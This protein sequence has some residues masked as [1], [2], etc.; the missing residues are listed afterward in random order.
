MNAPLKYIECIINIVSKCLKVVWIRVDASLN[1][2][3]NSRTSEWSYRQL[4]SNFLPF[5]KVC[6]SDRKSWRISLPYDL[7]L[8][9]HVSFWSNWYIES[10]LSIWLLWNFPSFFLNLLE[11][12]G[13]FSQICFLLPAAFREFATYLCITLLAWQAIRATFTNLCTYRYVLLLLC[14]YFVMRIP[15]IFCNPNRKN[16]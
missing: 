11:K 3:Q 5:K 15:G 12:D 2:N 13:K 7:R 6:F 8:Y 9:W 14:N 16:R 10:I 1:S 4:C